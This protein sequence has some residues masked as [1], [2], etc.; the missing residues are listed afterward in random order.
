LPNSL[1]FLKASVIG[2]SGF[3]RANHKDGIVRATKAEAEAN[4]AE[5]EGKTTE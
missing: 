2:E 3:P 5:F 1:P 4:E